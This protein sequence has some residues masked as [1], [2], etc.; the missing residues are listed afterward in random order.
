[1]PKRARPF[2]APRRRVKR[3]RYT[4]RRRTGYSKISRTL[5]TGIPPRTRTTLK[6]CQQFSLSSSSGAMGTQVFRASSVYDPD[7]SGIGHQPMYFD[8]LAALYQHYIVHKSK[9]YIE[10]VP[11]DQT[12]SSSSTFLLRGDDNASF[13]TNDV[14]TLMENR[15]T[16][17]ARVPIYGENQVLTRRLKTSYFKNK[18]FKNFKN[19]NLTAAV[20]TNPAEEW[21]FIVGLKTDDG[22]TTTTLNCW[23]TIYYD[24]E[25]FELKD[26]VGS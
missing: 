22:A 6:Y 18:T 8:Q 20:T 13:I 10:G 12:A 4:R 16:K 25:F 19:A 11:Y 26:V 9:I 7:Y 14:A 21:Y 15:G 24:V 5:G 3:T 23:V 2:A 17:Y 1:M